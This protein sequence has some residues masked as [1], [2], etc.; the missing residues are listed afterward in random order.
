MKNG[1]ACREEVAKQ[2]G[3]GRISVFFPWL[4]CNNNTTEDNT[5]IVFNC[6]SDAGGLIMQSSRLCVYN[7]LTDFSEVSKGFS[8][9]YYMCSI[10]INCHYFTT[11]SVVKIGDIVTSIVW[12]SVIFWAVTVCC[13]QNLIHQVQKWF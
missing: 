5:L 7:M 12:N 2:M 4:K 13:S 8:W 6:S 1:R 10:L 3:G 11:K 9:M